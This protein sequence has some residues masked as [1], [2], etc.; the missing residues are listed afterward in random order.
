M[1]NAPAETTAGAAPPDT[2]LPAE[3]SL[4]GE[5]GGHPVLAGFNRLSIVRQ[6]AVIGGIALVIA[7]SIAILLWS[8]EPTYKPLVHRLQDHNAQDIIEILQQEGINFEIDPGSQIL[9]VEASD[10]HEARMKLAAASLIDDKTVGLE[11]LDQDNPLGPSQFIENAR[12]RRGLEGELARTIASVK[13]VRNSRVH[14]ALPKQSVFVRDHRKPRASVFVE[15]YA[16]QDLSR[17]QVEAIVNLVASSV[18]EMERSDVSVVDQFGNLLSKLEAED[19]TEMV[20]HK[21]LEYSEKVEAGIAQAVNN[22]LKPVLGQGNYK[23]EVSA[24]VDFTVQE[25]SEELYNPDLIALRSEQLVDE[26]NADQA[27]GGIP[28]ALSNQPP[29]AATAP[30]EAAGGGQGGGTVS[31]RSEATRNYEVDRTL[32]Y[33]QQQVGRIRRLT[34]AVVVNDRA[35]LNEDGD[36]VYTPWEDADLQR[37]EVLVKDAVG[38]NA[39]RGDSVNVINSPFMGKGELELGDPDFWTQPWF[40]EIMKQVL[41]GLFILVLIFGVIRP[42]IKSIANRGRDEASVLLDELED[43]EA[44]LDDDK[45]TLAGMDDFLLP[46]ASESF[47]RQLDALKGLIAE[48]PARVANLVI[49]WVN[50]DNGGR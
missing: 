27:N 46:G 1:E 15:L 10:L 24:D 43:A 23:A 47:E 45:V 12:Y 36:T 3:S 5:E 28:G 2:E 20:A 38:F 21:Q 37:L 26:E 41:A 13:A 49:Q 8:Q 50:E 22:I 14:L 9:M 6:I 39:A 25:Q 16:G 17:D 19:S 34:V 48:D 32:S 29:P 4:N 44:G 42:T 18:A 11:V 33:K 31:R 7:L 40:W 35:S 30:E